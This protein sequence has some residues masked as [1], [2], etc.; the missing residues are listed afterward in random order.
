MCQTSAGNEWQRP[1]HAE[2]DTVH[3]YRF[4]VI[5]FSST[6]RAAE[7]TSGWFNRD[8]NVR[9][10]FWP[11]RWFLHQQLSADV[12]VFTTL[13]SHTDV[14]HWAF[15]GS[16]S[17]QEIELISPVICAGSACRDSSKPEHRERVLQLAVRT[18]SQKWDCFLF[19]YNRAAIILQTHTL[20]WLLVLRLWFDSTPSALPLLDYQIWIYRDQQII[21]CFPRQLDF[22]LVTFWTFGRLKF[23]GP[24]LKF[25]SQTKHSTFWESPINKV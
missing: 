5:K 20:I 9:L 21:G 1:A 10:T 14:W 16:L 8:R 13:S 22:I 24:N 4:V 25:Q 23:Y 2:V 18:G 3:G 11:W 19:L 6:F 7:V 12:L 15:R 17:R